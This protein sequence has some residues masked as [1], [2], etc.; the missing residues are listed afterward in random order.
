VVGARDAARLEAVVRSLLGGPGPTAPA[1]PLAEGAPLPRARPIL[2]LQDGCDARCSYC[3]VPLARGPSRSLPLADALS[4]IERLGRHADEV[5]LAG[6]N[7]GAW[8]RDLSPRASLAGLLERARGARRL[9]LS[10]LHPHEVPARL[11]ERACE[12]VHL[13]IQ[14]GSDRVLAAMRRPYRAAEVARAAE[15]V[16]RASPG[17]CLGADL[18]AGFPGESDAD[19]RAT[20]RLVEAL[21]LAY[22]HVFAYSPRPGTDAAGLARA[23]RGVVAARAEELRAL[24][25]RRRREFL[26]GLAG[27]ELEVLVERVAA[28]VAAGTSREYATVRWPAQGATRGRVARVR[29]GRVDASG[30]ALEGVAA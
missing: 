11:P 23:D 19:H 25:A 12:H 17:A 4:A 27:R 22:L 28:G 29:A 1:T 13:A 5:V 18:L 9:R 14:S 30:A 6:V 21:P 2:K 16:L 26:A 10:S 20:V 15:R 7:L 3:A 24:S 8:G